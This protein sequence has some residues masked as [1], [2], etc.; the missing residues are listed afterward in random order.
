[1]VPA[2]VPHII[3]SSRSWKQVNTDPIEVI[4]WKV[5]DKIVKSYLFDTFLNIHAS[6]S[7]SSSHRHWD[8]HLL[9]TSP[10]IFHSWRNILQGVHQMDRFLMRN[11][12]FANCHSKPSIKLCIIKY[13]RSS[14]FLD[15]CVSMEISL[16]NSQLSRWEVYLSVIKLSQHFLQRWIHFTYFN[17]MVLN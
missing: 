12:L 16:Y 15:T 7:W 13:F 14:F 17:E 4:F 11:F 6:I 9:V 8:Q 10:N 2:I 3:T 1:M 5:E